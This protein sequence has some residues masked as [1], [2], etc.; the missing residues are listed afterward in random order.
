MRDLPRTEVNIAACLVDEVGQPAPLAQV[1]PALQNLYEAQFVR[2]TEEGWKLQ[3]AQ[4]KNWETERRGHLSPKP[5]FR[6]EIAREALGEIFNDPKLKTYRY[7]DLKNFRVG[8]S[9]DGLGAG[10][11]GQVPLALVTAG[12]AAKFSTKL[13]EVRQESRHDS[14]KNNLYWVFAL[15]PEIDDLVANLY[16]SRQMVTKYD[17]L[18]AQNRITNEEVSCLGTEKGEVIRLKNRLRDK[19]LEALQA[20]TGLFQGVSKDGSALGKTVGEIFKGLFDFA[21]PDLYPKLELGARALKG[22]EA[23]EIL[24]AANLNGLGQVFYGGEQGLNLVIKGEGGKYVPNPEAD[25]AKEVLAYLAREHNYGNRESRTGKAIEAHFGGLGYGWDRDMLRLVLAALLRAGS[26]DVSYQ[27]Q[28]FDSYQDPRCRTPFTNNV[29]FKAALFTPTTPLDL[30]TLVKAVSSYE[31][32]TGQTVE[33]DKNAIAAAFKKLAQAQLQELL[34]V[35]A[36]VKA[37]Q[38]PVAGQ[39]AEWRT[40]LN[41]AADDCVRILAGEGAS[42]KEAQERLRQIREVVNGSGLATIRQARLAAQQM[43]PVLRERLEIGDWGLEIAAAELGEMAV[44]L[45]EWL[46]AEN[47][48]ETM[49]EIKTGA[50]VITTAYRTGYAGL[51]I[52]RAQ[53]YSAAIEEI[54]GQPDW[55]GVPAEMQPPL[56]NPL[57]LRA[58]ANLGWVDGLIVCQTCRATLSQMESDLAAVGGLKAQALARIVEITTPPDTSEVKPVRVRLIEFFPDSLETEQALDEAVERLREHLVK[59]LAEGVKIIPE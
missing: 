8:V 21:V 38:L 36:E 33:V 11:E 29:A 16:A 1:Q 44:R 12:D 15:T 34:P 55:A 49:T 51:H 43:W 39:L 53:G 26:I 13:A 56:L 46:Q 6:T 24:K 18:R 28:R 42:L 3:T 7:R 9:V 27:G 41:S 47:F 32:L 58:C 22:T 5:K 30:K 2:H 17:Q 4:E 40:N 25:V 57:A 31:S 50:E 20:G 59:L 35:E 54:K 23:E 48:Y 10:D 14:H 45:G 52:Q 19:L 37:Y